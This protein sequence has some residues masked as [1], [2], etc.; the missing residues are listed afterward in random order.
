MPMKKNILPL[1]VAVGLI[2]SASAQV[3]TGDLANG[4]VAY[5]SLNG[6]AN[7]SVGGNNGTP[8]GDPAATTDR[9]GNLSG[10]LLFNGINQ[11]IAAADQNFPKIS[12]SFTLSIWVNPTGNESLGTESTYGTSYWHNYLISGIQG[13]DIAGGICL[14]VGTNGA[15]VI[16]SGNAF[17]P[18]TLSY[19]C[20]ITNWSMITVT[21]RNNG[22]ESIYINGN[23][24]A[25]GLDSGRIKIAS[26][27]AGDS[28]QGI[29][30]GGIWSLCG[31]G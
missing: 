30:G 16:E 2:G 5:Y 27:F 18:V 8:I 23:Y 12:N 11:S 4:L 3:P 6:N 7:D 15:S 19:A 25:S 29:G 20:S 1:L 10:A 17:L 31:I 28:Y 9:F 14:A 21:C 24:V 26:V 13:G 22:A